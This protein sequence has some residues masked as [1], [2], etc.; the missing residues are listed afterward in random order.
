MNTL[1][2]IILSVLLIGATTMVSPSFA[3]A[4]DQVCTQ[5]YGQPVVCGVKTPEYPKAGLAEDLRIVGVLFLGAAVVLYYKS[6][7]KNSVIA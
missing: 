2:T 5:G 6:S 4:E 1:K 3:A 7:T